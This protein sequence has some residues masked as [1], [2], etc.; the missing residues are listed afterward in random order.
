MRSAGSGK[1]DAPEDERGTER[2][3]ERKSG[4][5]TLT[6]SP[7]LLPGEPMIPVSDEQIPMGDEWGYQL[8]W[9]GVRLLARIGQG[10]AELYSRRLLPK[11]SAYPELAGLLASSVGESC[12]LDGE[13]FVFD[14]ARQRPVFRRVLERERLRNP[15]AIA[16]AGA[17]EP[18][19]FAV[20][21]VLHSQ[22]RDWRERPYRERHRELLRLL[23]VKQERLFVTDLFTDGAG[24]WS[25]VEAQGWE[26]IVSK[27]LDSTYKEGKKHRDWLK[28]KTSI[29]EEVDIVGIT[30]NEGRLA[31]LIMALEGSYFGRVSLGLDEQQKLRLGTLPVRKPQTP[32]DAGPFLQLPADL[33][34]VSLAWLE[35]PFCCRVTGLEVTDAGLL[36]HSKLLSLP[37]S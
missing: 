7:I 30:Y 4:P 2:G 5:L 28:K 26:G 33:K 20:F 8:K 29:R 9:D 27:R 35:Q 22:G 13:A 37:F 16:R 31:S 23:P 21:D 12:L 10:S 18:V 6:P 15:A 25:W 19:R 24:L 3:A 17:S 1:R 36:R 11:N 34:R 32:A 14:Q